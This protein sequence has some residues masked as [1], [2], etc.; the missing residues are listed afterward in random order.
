MTYIEKEEWWW[1]YCQPKSMPGF[2]MIKDE[3]D[4]TI[5]HIELERNWM[6]DRAIEMMCET[7]NNLKEDERNDPLWS[8]CWRITQEPA[9]AE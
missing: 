8:N 3:E 2:Y 1:D 4:N 7:Y 9:Q 5:A 6:Y